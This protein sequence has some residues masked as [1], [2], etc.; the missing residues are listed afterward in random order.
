MRELWKFVNKRIEAD[1]TKQT[2]FLILN[3][4]IWSTATFLAGI[5]IGLFF[6][7]SGMD[8]LLGA[9]LAACYAGVFVGLMGG[10]IFLM[11]NTTVHR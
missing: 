6:K 8:V 3:T 5:L 11:R 2:V 1:T 9:L 4:V 7:L 10:C